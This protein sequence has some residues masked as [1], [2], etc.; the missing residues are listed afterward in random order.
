M[1]KT[2]QK[3][4]SQGITEIEL[5]K[6]LGVEKNPTYKVAFT[7]KGVFHNVGTYKDLKVAK[8]ARDKKRVELGLDPIDLKK[9]G[10]NLKNNDMKVETHVFKSGKELKAFLK[11]VE[12]MPTAFNRRVKEPH[13]KSMIKSVE[14]IGIQRS[15]NVINTKAFTG[16]STLYTA[17]GQHLTRGILNI[18]DEQ[19]KGHFVVFVNTIDSI[20]KIIPF[21]SLMNSTAKNWALDDYLNAWV[22][23]GLKDYEYIKTIKITTGYS[24]SGIIEAFSNKPATGN[25]DFKSGVFKADKASGKKIIDLYQKAVIMG[26]KESNSAFLGLTRY[27]LSTPEI[28]EV[29]FLKGVK[30]EKH[31]GSNFNRDA[32]IALFKNIPM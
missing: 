22:T 21:V 30:K 4:V 32:F 17:D 14:T 28:D 12:C 6:D 23:H 8:M 29:K 20:N 2:Q 16:K 25:T 9:A 27:Y 19:L 11:N 7:A 18:P 24:L 15:I 10:A 26:L 3:T 13:V 1:Y 31:F 5:Q